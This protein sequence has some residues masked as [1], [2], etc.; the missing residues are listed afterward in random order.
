MNEPK[1]KILFVDDDKDTCEL[2]KF[3]FE[4]AGYQVNAFNSAGEGLLEARKGNYGAIIL[5][6]WFA[7]AS[8]VEICKHIRSFDTDTPI[9]FFSGEARQNEIDKAL[10]SGATAYLI[11][12]N[13]F[14]RL[15]ET[16]IRVI[17]N[18]V[19]LS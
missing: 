14:E 18:Q 3:V 12:P 5:D 7:E 8:G 11:K 6:H 19:L 13:D 17:K 16:V 10:A 1:S 2:I 9:I 15:T 4:Q